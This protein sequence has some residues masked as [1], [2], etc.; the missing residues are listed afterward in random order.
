M[1]SQFVTADPQFGIVRILRPYKGFEQLYQGRPAS[2]QIM[3]TEVVQPPGG[4]PLDPFAAQK[5]DGYD[6]QLVRG[7]SVPL[8][9]RVILWLPKILPLTEPEIRYKWTIGWRLRNLFDYRNARIP[10]H[11]PKQGEGARDTTH[12]GPGLPRV[13]IPA[14]HQTVIYNEEPQPTG[15]REPVAANMRIED[16][17]TGGDYPTVG[18]DYLGLPINPDGSQGAIQ[19]GVLDPGNFFGGFGRAQSPFWQTHEVQAFGVE[20]CIGLWRDDPDAS[21]PGA[22]P[23]WDFAGADVTVRNFLGAG[24]EGVTPDVGVYAICGSAP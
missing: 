16:V 23:N 3:M 19:Q 22:A 9:C 20:L 17:T 15:V 1:T 10:Y 12:G 8:G 6:P 4:D 5:K 14:A 21:G 7:L 2:D 24:D 18:T 11:Y 13:V